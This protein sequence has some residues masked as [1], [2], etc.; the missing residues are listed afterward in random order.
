MACA[1]CIC[2]SQ[3]SLKF[4]R[5][6]PYI[7][8]FYDT[9]LWKNLFISYSYTNELYGITCRIP[10]LLNW[11]IIGNWIAQWQRDIIIWENKVQIKIDLFYNKIIFLDI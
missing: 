4:D 11:Y 3:T 9:I 7:A 10:R 2:S 1:I 6:K 5:D 8:Y